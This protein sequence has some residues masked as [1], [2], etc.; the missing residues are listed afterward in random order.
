MKTPMMKILIVI[1]MMIVIVN[2]DLEKN[3]LEIDEVIEIIKR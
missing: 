2:D 1:P 3:N